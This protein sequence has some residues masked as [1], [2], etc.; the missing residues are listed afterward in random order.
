MDLIL[1]LYSIWRRNR[2][3]LIDNGGAIYGC[4]YQVG[5]NVCIYEPLCKH[6]CVQIVHAM[7][8]NYL[9]VLGKWLIY[10]VY[11]VKWLIQDCVF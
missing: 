2:Y 3:W 4:W 5:V 8:Q 1:H 11:L 10:D 7:F 9:D 6:V